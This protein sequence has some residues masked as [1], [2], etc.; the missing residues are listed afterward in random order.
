MRVDSLT[1]VMEAISSKSTHSRV[2]STR[3][4][5]DYLLSTLHGQGQFLDRSDFEVSSISPAL[6]TGGRSNSV[7]LKCQPR[8]SHQM[9]GI[10]T[11]VKLSPRAEAAEEYLR[12]SRY[13]RLLVSL[14]ARVELLGYVPG[15]TL[16]AICYSFAGKTP[17]VVLGLNDLFEARDDRASLVLNNLFA[18]EAQCWYATSGTAVAIPDFL[19]HPYTLK[20]EDVIRAVSETVKKT[21]AKLAGI[22]LRDEGFIW[23]GI[24]IPDPLQTLGSGTMA[25]RYRSCI[26]HGDMNANNI[27]TAEDGRAI[28][29]DYRHTTV[30]PRALDFAA[31][32]TSIRLASVTSASTTEDI[33]KT[34]K[35][36]TVTWKTN[37]ASPNRFPQVDRGVAYWQKISSQL[38]ALARMNFQDLTALEY[39]CACFGWIAR[40]L[41]VALPFEQRLRL[42]CWM[43]HLSQ[44]IEGHKS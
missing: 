13:V 7:V 15:D 10:W 34:F 33:L 23:N 28:M 9:N 24:K 12:Y 43:G 40:M 37:W 36:E 16:G 19:A 35:L 14:D 1:E 3:D 41:R 5:I 18:P 30:G 39:A 21:Q 17:N 25:H 42:I 27:I 6:M 44:I 22:Q 31:L 29:I 4:E 2:A 26:I 32:E 20:T 38:T 8:T 11:V